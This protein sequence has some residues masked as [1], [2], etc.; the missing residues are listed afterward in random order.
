M[1]GTTRTVHPSADPVVAIGIALGAVARK[2]IACP[3]HPALSVRC[4]SRSRSSSDRESRQC[5]CTCNRIRTCVRLCSQSPASHETTRAHGC[6]GRPLS[7][8][9]PHCPPCLPCECGR[10]W[11]RSEVCRHVAVVVAVHGAG[12]GRPRARKAQHPTHIA[13]VEHAARLW[14]QQR[15]HNAEKGERRR[16]RLG[17][18]RAGQRADHNG[19]RLCL[20]KGV[21]QRTPPAANVLVVPPPRLTPCPSVKILHHTTGADMHIQGRRDR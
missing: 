5:T 14:V 13:P 3:P 17:G 16:P 7:H 10:A 18:R 4:H 6:A 11:V 19:A 2:V 20:P 8:T 9:L 12:H 21:H 1:C 15:R